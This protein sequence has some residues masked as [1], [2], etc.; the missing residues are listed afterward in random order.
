MTKVEVLLASLAPE[1]KERSRC[2]NGDLVASG[3]YVLYWMRTA[4]RADENPALEVA[5]DLANRLNIP[6]FVYHALSERYPYASDRHHTFIIEGARDVQRAMQER[7]VGYAFHLERPGQSKAYLF[8]L[9]KQ[10]AVVITED[11]P[12]RPLRDWTKQLARRV[13]TPLIAVDTACVVPMQV[14]GRAYDRAFA[15]R[16][17]TEKAYRERLTRKLE[18]TEPKYPSYLPQLPFNAVDLIDADIPD[19]IAQCR[20]DHA[21][22]PVP[23]TRGGTEAGYERWRNF[24]ENGL[25]KYARVRNNALHNGVSRMSAYLHYGM[26]SPFRI[27]RETAELDHE[28]AEKFLDELTIWRELA[29]AFCFHRRDHDRLSALP[30]W[31][32]DTLRDHEQDE[33]DALLSWE[34]LARG[35]TGDALWDA[36]QSSLLIHGELHNNVRMTWGKALLSWTKD[37]KQALSV[38]IDLNHRYALDGRDPASYGGILWCLGQFDRPF[39]PGNRILGTVRDRSTKQH[40]KRLDPKLFGKRTRRPLTNSMP[41]V[42][43]VGAG[44]SGLMCARTLSDHGFEVQVFEKSR[45]A[46]G[47]MATRRGDGDLRFDHGAQYFTARDRRFRRY[48]NSW[49]QD[50]L[51]EPWAGRLVSLARGEILAEKSGVDRFVGVPGMNAICKH[52]AQD[53]DVDYGVTVEPLTRKGDRW[54]LNT[55]ERSDL[56]IFDVAIVSAP[57]P[58]AAILVAGQ[59][60]MASRIAEVPMHECWA[61]MLALEQ[62]TELDFD[63]AFVNDSPLAWISRNSSKPGRSK[64]NET[65]VLHASSVW[66]RENLELSAETVAEELLQAFTA[67][68]G[69][70]SLKIERA[71]A[72]RW[73]YALPP[74]P[75]ADSCVFDGERKIGCCGDWCGGP[76]VEG[77]FLS[78][79]AAA[80]RVLGLLDC[81]GEPTVAG[82]NQKTLF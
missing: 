70:S 44:L 32:R 67:A 36:A 52:L 31:A 69:L 13:T 51:V 23:H 57:A 55:K 62:R 7:R 9:A 60:P 78:G 66:S 37:A 1:L 61:V 49:R 28:G 56:G 34:S 15:Y 8:D 12:V 50:G 72:H 47:R 38:L 68:T 39:P 14:V 48:V 40:A 74:E 10:S 54:L 80:G 21:I 3:S 33:R 26:V 16:K 30:S 4:V 24:R 58:Q 27:A 43:V 19:L 46:G 71:V 6:A 59:T 82:E 35:V 22:G 42:A 2:I 11:M 73:R 63:G 45:G 18:P 53:L 65:W 25:S 17:A 64:K 77:A 20:I 75:L 76:R 29:Y 41:R 5:I 79:M 81:E